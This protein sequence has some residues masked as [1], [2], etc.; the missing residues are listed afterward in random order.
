MKNTQIRFCLLG[1][2]IVFVI[3]LSMVFIGS[4]QQKTL[5]NDDLLAITLDGKKISALDKLYH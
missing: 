5:N 1:I 3:L 4:K 2:V